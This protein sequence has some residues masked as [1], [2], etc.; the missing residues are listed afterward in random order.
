MFDLYIVDLFV[1]LDPI[2]C[3]GDLLGASWRIVGDD[4]GTGLGPRLVRPEPQVN[5][6]LLPGANEAGHKF[7]NPKS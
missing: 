2:A 3:D 5:D 7:T 1:F 6:A 4:Q